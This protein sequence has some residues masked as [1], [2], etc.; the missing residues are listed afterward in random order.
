MRTLLLIALIIAGLAVTACGDDSADT[1]GD[2][3]RPEATGADAG[4][5]TQP[6]PGATATASTPDMSAIDPNAPAPGI[7]AVEGDVQT[8]STG[9]QY[10]IVEEGTGA[11]PTATQTVTVHYTGWLTDGTKFDSSVDRGQTATFQLNGVIPGWT[12]GLQL[13]KQGGKI[14]LIIPS[15]L[16]YGPQGRPPVIPANADLIFDVE[17]LGIQ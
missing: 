10:I 5:P 7:P 6:A 12:E 2:T 3:N 15:D 8:T 13:V 14:R 4:N 17:L 1:G 16:A 11:S 9:L